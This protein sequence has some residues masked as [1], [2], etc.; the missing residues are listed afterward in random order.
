MN[1]FEYIKSQLP[2]MPNIQIMKDL[3]ASDELVEYVKKT[4]ENTNL[5]VMRSITSS[6]G[7]AE[8]WLISTAYEDVDEIRILTLS[9]TEEHI[10]ELFSNTNHYNVYLQDIELPYYFEQTMEQMTIKVWTDTTV[11]QNFTKLVRLI[12]SNDTITCQAAYNH[13]SIAPTSV[14]VSVK[15]K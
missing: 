2:Q 13:A 11:P 9:G 3:G 5:N 6:G 1:L 4:P 14:E 12:S 7:D 8:V 15:A 10:T